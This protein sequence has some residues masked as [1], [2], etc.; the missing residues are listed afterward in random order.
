MLILRVFRAE[1]KLNK[2][3]LK[4]NVS[5]VHGKFVTCLRNIATQVVLMPFVA[6]ILLEPHNVKLEGKTIL[7]FP[8]NSGLQ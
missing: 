1:F 5:I 3:C 6:K 2:Y 7:P 8:M 4:K